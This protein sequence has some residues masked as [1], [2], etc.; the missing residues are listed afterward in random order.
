MK[1]MVEVPKSTE[2]VV[3][4]PWREA[5]E[6]NRAVH[7]SGRRWFP[8]LRGR[9]LKKAWVVLLFL[10]I[11]FPILRGRLL[12]VSKRIHLRCWTCVSNP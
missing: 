5:I 3:S 1:L 11:E 6:G 10:F 12:K 9:L 8:I 4:N 7:R 2:L